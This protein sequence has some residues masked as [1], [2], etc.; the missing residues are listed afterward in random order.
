MPSKASSAFGWPLPSTDCFVGDVDGR[1]AGSF[2]KSVRKGF[3]ESGRAVFG[4]CGDGMPGEGIEGEGLRKG[5]LEGGFRVRA[6]AGSRSGKEEFLISN[7]EC[8]RG[9]G[10]G[11]I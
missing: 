1:A 2:S 3:R 11:I 10:I 9:R 6:G 4:L 8:T 5:F 7:Q